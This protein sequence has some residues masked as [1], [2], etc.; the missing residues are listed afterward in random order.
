MGRELPSTVRDI[1]YAHPVLVKMWA[2]IDHL[3]AKLEHLS[4][5]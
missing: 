2:E 3:R 5:R 1:L 4:D